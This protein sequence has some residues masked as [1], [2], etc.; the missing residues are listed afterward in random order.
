MG[1]SEAAKK[2]A[3]EI[4]RKDVVDQ[5]VEA[6]LPLKMQPS[7][8]HV[9]IVHVDEDG[10]VSFSTAELEAVNITS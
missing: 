9:L 2:A 5:L 3:K 4:N 1:I 6:V 10:D 8:S 7:R